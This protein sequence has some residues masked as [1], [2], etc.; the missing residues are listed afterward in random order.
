MKA[1]SLIHLVIALVLGFVA[2]AL[3]AFWYSTVSEQSQYV[4]TLQSHIDEATSNVNR[5]AAARAALA[6]IASD[7][8]TVQAYFVPETGVVSF[9]SALEELGA[10]HKATVSVLSVSTAGTTAEPLLTLTLS[11]SGT[12]D[13]VMRTVGAIEYAPYD[14]SITRLS[15]SEGEKGNWQASLALSVG[16][17]PSATSTKPKP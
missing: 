13:A 1:S 7:E 10:S 3:Y 15:V 4:A 12:F 5:I 9:I 11:I 2:A 16:S 17:A 14:L 6:E 8:A